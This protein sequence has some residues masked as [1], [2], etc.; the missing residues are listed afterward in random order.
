[1]PLAVVVL[2]RI[3]GGAVTAVALVVTPASPGRSTRSLSALIRSGR[4][5]ALSGSVGTS[6]GTGARGQ[7]VDDDRRE[8]TALPCWASGKARAAALRLRSHS[9]LGGKEG[10]LACFIVEA[11]SSIVAWRM[12]REAPS[13]SFVDMICGSVH[14]ST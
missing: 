10:R 12:L 1:M 8:A 13:S 4:A 2:P 6:G 5:T 14:A 7:V 9:S 3:W 11:I